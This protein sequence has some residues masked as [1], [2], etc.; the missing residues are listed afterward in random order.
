[1]RRYILFL[2]KKNKIK[3]HYILFSSSSVSQLWLRWSSSLRRRVSR[4]LLMYSY[5]T[6]IV[7]FLL[8]SMG[9]LSFDHCEQ[10]NNKTWQKPVLQGDTY[11][12]LSGWLYSVAHIDAWE[13]LGHWL[14][15]ERLQQNAKVCISSSFLYKRMLYHT[16][17]DTYAPTAIT[18]NLGV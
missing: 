2:G 12:Q 8:Y 7:L 15:T 3:N 17:S 9:F 10:S 13:D 11:L 18:R 1:M 4:C 16:S 5:W 14:V 6:F